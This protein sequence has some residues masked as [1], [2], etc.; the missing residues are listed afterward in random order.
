MPRD[1]PVGNGSMLVNFDT[2]YQLRDI[3]W[4]HVGMANH[5]GGGLCRLGVWVNGQFRW[6]DDSGWHRI[7]KYLPDTLV[8]EVTLFHPDL[9]VEIHCHDFV[10]FHHDVF[11]RKFTLRNVSK[12]V[13]Q[14]RFFLA[15]D[16]SLNG[17]EIGDAAYYEP[18]RKVLFHYKGQTWFLLAGGRQMEDGTI[19]VGFDGWAVGNKKVNGLEGTWRDAE[20]GTLS[21]N[22][23]AQG[24]I[25]SVVALHG[26]L[27]PNGTVVF[28]HW[29][30]AGKDFSQ[31]TA[32]NRAIRSKGPQSFLVRTRDYWRLW[33]NKE[34][35]NF[36]DF[37]DS[38]CELCR[39]SLLVLRTQI[40]NDGAILAAN[41]HDFTN[42]SR[43]TYSYMWPRDGALV[44]ATLVGVGYSEISRRF[45][46]FCHRVIT[47]EGYLLHKFTPDGSLASSWH[48]W[49]REGI[50][51][52]PIQED[53][54]AL[55]LWALWCHF[56]TFRDIEFLKL[57]YRGLV[58]RAANWMI[59]Y[60]NPITGLPRPSWD[61]W[62]ERY[63]VHA[64]TV[65][66]V[67]AGLRA[68][69]NFTEAFGQHD[70]AKKFR[71][72]AESIKQAAMIH[73][74]SKQKNRYVRTLIVAVD[75]TLTP[76]FTIDASLVGLW[77]FG[78]LKPDDDRVV[79]T[80]QAVRQRLWVQTEAGGLARYENDSYHQVSRDTEKVAGN[81][82]FIT[83]LWYA[84]WRI[85]I[86]SNENDLAEAGEL[87][88]WAADRALPSGI[89]A[90]QI[91]PYTNTP[92]SVSPLTWSHATLVMTVRQY[93]DKLATF[94]PLDKGA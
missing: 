45:F 22:S 11:L 88:E 64:W 70:K 83:T 12:D 7:L 62:E 9:G 4:P 2:Y 21:G 40:D 48:G 52:L 58:V 72:A 61:L 31:V 49:Y 67:W 16:L 34:S 50:K 86:A 77:Y 25:D 1:I 68:A 90:E 14:V 33:A 28:W 10:D 93:I 65:G 59:S 18:E 76:D 60:C 54:T 41:D 73:L 74:W 13:K 29:L 57:H 6:S 47:E 3:F 8:T 30:A 69:G 87:I 5:T 46:D 23:V 43:D 56:D 55:V 80:M 35:T 84:Q 51:E 15:Y 71:D 79:A 78:M 20:D 81:P 44:A 92:L 91:H 42:F 82:W 53:E 32:I 27:A 19:A 75:G 26:D 24:S 94:T 38:V 36:A 39:R 17:N 89:M 85:A 66:A 37:S 63:G